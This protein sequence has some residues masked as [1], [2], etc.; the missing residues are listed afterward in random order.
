MGSKIDIKQHSTPDNLHNLGMC[1]IFWQIGDQNGTLA[2]LVI[3][4]SLGFGLRVVVS[5]ILV[6]ECIRAILVGILVVLV[7]MVVKAVGISWLII[8]VARRVV[9]VDFISTKGVILLSRRRV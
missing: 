4:G 5:T 9:G 3:L 7:G 2:E 6:V 1:C 8:A